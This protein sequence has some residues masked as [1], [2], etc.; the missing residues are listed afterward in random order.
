MKS[1]LSALFNSAHRLLFWCVE[2][3]PFHNIRVVD[4]LFTGLL[5]GLEVAPLVDGKISARLCPEETRL[6]RLLVVFHL[7]LLILQSAADRVRSPRCVPN[8]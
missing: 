6:C 3:A 2:E 1:S 5:A 7:N 8:S 4:F